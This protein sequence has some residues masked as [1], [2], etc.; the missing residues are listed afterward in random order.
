MKTAQLQEYMKARKIDFSLFFNFEKSNPNTFYFAK[1]NGLGCL[2]VPKGKKKFMIVPQMDE[3][4]ARKTGSRVVVYT[5]DFYTVLRKQLKTAKLVGIE[6]SHLNARQYS[7]LRR[8]L[9]ARVCDIGPQCQKLRQEKADSEI[10]QIKK[11]CSL[12]EKILDGCVRNF[13]YRTEAEIAAKLEY[14]ARRQ[15]AEVSFPPIVASGKNSSMPHHHAGKQKIRKGFLIIDFGVTLNGYCSDITKTFYVGTPNKNELEIY[16]R[17]LECQRAIIRQIKP[18]ITGKR[19]SLIGDKVLGKYKTRMIHS[20][21]HGLGVEVHEAPSINRYS[22]EKLKLG[23]VVSIEPGIYLKNK[24]GVR[25][26]SVV[27]VGKS[28]A[29]YLSTPHSGLIRLKQK[30]Y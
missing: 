4:V 8:K 3:E 20:Y 21:G 1:Y 6:K 11:S 30:V 19:L 22:K 5:R 25:L 13:T 28:S 10:V 2:V 17:V 26:E 14:E 16:S 12:A 15:G 9:R 27:V 23:N 24:Y 18:G 7:S 29:L